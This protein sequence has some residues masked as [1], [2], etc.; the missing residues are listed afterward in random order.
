MAG[1]MVQIL[2]HPWRLPYRFSRRWVVQ[3]IALA[4]QAQIYCGRDQIEWQGFADA[5]SLFVEVESAPH[6]LSELLRKDQRLGPIHDIFGYV[7]ALGASILVE[8]I[9]NLFRQTDSERKPLLSLEYLVTHLTVSDASNPRDTIDGLL[10]IAD[11][12]M[13]QSAEPQAKSTADI[14]LT[15]TDRVK[16]QLELLGKSSFASQMYPVE[17]KLLYVDMCKD[18]VEFAIHKAARS[19]P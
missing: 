6:R 14:P 18:F 7:S 10:A 15:A 1:S 3:E 11:G 13:L 8:E 2:N 9:G 17:Y 5:V 19:E 16:E 4:K 12:T